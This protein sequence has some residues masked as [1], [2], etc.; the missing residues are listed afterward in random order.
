MDLDYVNNQLSSVKGI[1]NSC[2]IHCN[3]YTRANL[4]NGKGR[5]Q[6]YCK[7]RHIGPMHEENILGNT[8]ITSIAS[9][10]FHYQKCE[11]P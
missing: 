7:Y 11:S 4:N 3:R 8:P 6:F 1:Y 5:E 10:R 2:K 9:F